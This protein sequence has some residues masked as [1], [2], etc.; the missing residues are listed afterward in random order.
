MNTNSPTGTKPAPGNC[1][2]QFRFLILAAAI[3]HVAIAGAV[4]TAGKLQLMPS[5]FAPSGL[6][7]FASDG[8]VYQN[9]AVELSYVL[10]SQGLAAWA[11]WPTPAT[12][13]SSR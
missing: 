4:F 10:K 5:Q 3:L 9:E 6:A 13:C 12:T 7:A 2:G 11:I 8:Y 1:R